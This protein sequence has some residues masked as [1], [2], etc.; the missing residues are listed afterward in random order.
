MPPIRIAIVDDH[1]VARWGV[2]HVFESHAD[3]QVVCSVASVEELEAALA[4]PGVAGVDV[5]VVDLYLTGDGPSLAVI[6]R[7]AQRYRVLVMSASGRREDVLAAIRAGADGYLTKQAADDAFLAGV[8]RVAAGELYLSSQ[9]ADLIHADLEVELEAA[10]PAGDR[11][12]LAPRER[13]TLRYIAQGF[14]HAQAARRMG[15]SQA[16]VETYIK[17]IRQKLR[18]GNKADLTRTAIELHE[19]SPASPPTL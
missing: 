12:R 19:V 15:V 8:E 4:A 5:V 14:T 2:E 6:E 10:A 18:V 17:R 9:L 3:V 11:P 13:E 1:P 16:T 7:L